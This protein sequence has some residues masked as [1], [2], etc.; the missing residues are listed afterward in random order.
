MVHR[1]HGS[2]PERGGMGHGTYLG[3]SMLVHRFQG[4]LPDRA[5]LGHGTDLG[6]SV[7]EHR[8]LGSLP[9]VLKNGTVLVLLFTGYRYPLPRGG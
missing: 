2:L 9:E 8:F 3:H 5:G 4:S 6:H 7:L 1:F